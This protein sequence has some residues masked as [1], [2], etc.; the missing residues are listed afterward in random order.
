MFISLKSGVFIFFYYNNK[1]HLVFINLNSLLI[2]SCIINARLKINNW[3][4]EAHGYNMHNVA[5]P[6]GMAVA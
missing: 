1:S 6:Q 2:L 4:T 5:Y 3:G